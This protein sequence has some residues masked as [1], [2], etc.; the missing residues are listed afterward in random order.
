MLELIRQQMILG[1]MIL[2]FPYREDYERLLKI[3]EEENHH[4]YKVLSYDTSSGTSIISSSI[5]T[6]LLL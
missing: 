1:T 3:I 6:L 4:R 5:L 2:I